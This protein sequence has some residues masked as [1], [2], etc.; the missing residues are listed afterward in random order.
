[1]FRIQNKKYGDTARQGRKNIQK[2]RLQKNPIQ[3]RSVVFSDKYNIAHKRGE[4]NDCTYVAQDC[5]LTDIL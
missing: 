5:D 2:S 4:D 3:K 1:M